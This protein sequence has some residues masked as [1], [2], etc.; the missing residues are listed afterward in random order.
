MPALMLDPR[1]RLVAKD[2]SEFCIVLCCHGETAGGAWIVSTDPDA[3][4]RD[5]Q[6]G[7]IFFLPKKLAER[8]EVCGGFERMDG[9]LQRKLVPLHEFSMPK[10]LAV[11]KGLA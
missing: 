2:S 4:S 7:G 1:G 10:F 9:H 8:G 6:H 3:R 11:Q 5:P